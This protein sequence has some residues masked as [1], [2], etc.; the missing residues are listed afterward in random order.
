MVAVSMVPVQLAWMLGLKA[1]SLALFFQSLPMGLS[2]SSS[3]IPVTLPMG[4]FTPPLQLFTLDPAPHV[5]RAAGGAYRR[6]FL[7]VQIR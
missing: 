5:N 4:F 1:T 7:R 2:S 3:S 6:S